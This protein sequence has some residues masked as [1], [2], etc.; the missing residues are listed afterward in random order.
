VNDHLPLQ[1]SD[2]KLLAVAWLDEQLS[3]AESEFMEEH[4]KNC[5][6]CDA[7]IHSLAQQKFDLPQLNIVEND[8]YW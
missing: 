3:P 4:L 5:S 2:V 6:E 8:A 7:F 1:C